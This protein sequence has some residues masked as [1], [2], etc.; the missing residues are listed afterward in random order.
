VNLRAFLLQ[1][2]TIQALTRQCGPHKLT[3]DDR[4]QTTDDRRQTTGERHTTTTTTKERKKMKDARKMKGPQN[5][6]AWALLKNGH[7]AGR[8]VANWSDNP[9]GTVCTVWFALYGFD[10]NPTIIGKGR[11]G[12]YGY[13]KLSA[14]TYQALKAAGITPQ[15]V[16]PANGL[17]RKEFEA[18][19][20]EV[21]EVI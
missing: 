17:T 4:R 7:L 5:T 20:Y 15:V 6:T 16:Q 1:P 3:T 12:G 13:D 8:F 14:A 21:A 10:N 2:F 18:M 9:N 19:G 11:A